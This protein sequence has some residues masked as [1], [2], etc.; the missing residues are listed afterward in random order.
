MK[1]PTIIFLLTSFYTEVIPSAHAQERTLGMESQLQNAVEGVIALN[2]SYT[3]P[4]TAEF[5]GEIN[6]VRTI[7]RAGLNTWEADQTNQ[8][9][10]VKISIL[11]IALT[12]LFSPIPAID[13][14]YVQ[15]SVKHPE[16]FQ[17]ALQ[18]LPSTIT[19]DFRKE[20]YAMQQEEKS[21]NN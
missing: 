16:A 17:N 10:L 2:E 12:D 11:E 7:A 15:L 6:R 19:N 9:L 14:L 13:D 3:T 18:T 1:L 8:K 21:G 20:L 5:N 4:T